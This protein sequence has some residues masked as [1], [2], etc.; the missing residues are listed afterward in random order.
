MDARKVAAQFAAHAWYEEVRA[1]DQPSPK[2]AARFARRNWTAFTSVAP[3]GLGRLLLT[4]AAKR[5]PLR[6]LRRREQP[7]LALAQ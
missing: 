7:G 1:E 2:E 5:R 6:R 4:I 3:E